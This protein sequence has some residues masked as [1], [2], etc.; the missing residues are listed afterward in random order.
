MPGGSDNKPQLT[1]HIGYKNADNWNIQAELII[2]K[3]GLPWPR[4]KCN[5]QQQQGTQGGWQQ[6]QSPPQET[7]GAR[8]AP[9]N[10]Y[11]TAAPDPLYYDQEEDEDEPD[12]ADS[13]DEDVPTDEERHAQHD[14]RAQTPNQ[15]RDSLFTPSP[16]ARERAT[17]EFRR[18]ASQPVPPQHGTAQTTAHGI[19]KFGEKD[20]AAQ[21]AL[22][23][24]IPTSMWSDFKLCRTCYD[25]VDVVQKR[26]KFKSTDAQR[27][28]KDK[29]E[30]LSL[31]AF[32]DFDAY[33]RKGTELKEEYDSH[34]K[35]M[36]LRD[37]VNHMAEGLPDDM[38]SPYLY[39]RGKY[40]NLATL[41]GIK[42][43]G[44]VYAFES[45]LR[46][47]MYTEARRRQKH[48]RRNKAKTDRPAGPPPPP[49]GQQFQRK[50]P[51]R[52]LQANAATKGREEKKN[53]NASDQKCGH[54]GKTRHTEATC[55]DLHPELRTQRQ[56]QLKANLASLQQQIAYVERYTPA[57]P[58]EQDAGEDDDN[59]SEYDNCCARLLDDARAERNSFHIVEHTHAA[60]SAINTSTGGAMEEF[61]LDSGCEFSNKPSTNGLGHLRRANGSYQGF[62][63]T[64]AAI[65]RQGD[66]LLGEGLNVAFNVV[67]KARQALLA[68]SQV[69][70]QQRLTLF[71]S[72]G[73]TV[74]KPLSPAKLQQLRELVE[75]EEEINFERK[76]G[77]YIYAQP[78][79]EEQAQG[80]EYGQDHF[81]GAARYLPHDDATADETG[82][83]EA[84]TKQ[85]KLTRAIVAI[86]TL[87][88]L[89]WLV[90]VPA[91][92][93]A[94]LSQQRVHAPEYK[95]MSVR[96]AH[97]CESH[98]CLTVHAASLRACPAT[99]SPIEE[100]KGPSKAD[101]DEDEGVQARL[102][103]DPNG[104][105]YV[106]HKVI[107]PSAERVVASPGVMRLHSQHAHAG[108]GTLQA[109]HRARTFSPPLSRELAVDLMRATHLDCEH[110]GEAKA[111]ATA[112]PKTT[113]TLTAPMQRL[114]VDGSFPT[115][116][117]STYGNTMATVAVDVYSK[118]K[119]GLY[120]KSRKQV[121]EQ[122]INLIDR[123]ERATGRKLQEL[124]LDLAPELVQGRLAEAMAKRGITIIPVPPE[125]HQH[126]G[127]AERAVGVCERGMNALMSESDAPPARWE[128]AHR[129]FI[130]VANRTL[131]ANAP[132]STTPDELFTERKRGHHHWIPFGQ[133]VSYKRTGHIGAGEYAGE[134]GIMVGYEPKGAYRI[135]R[136]SNHS[137]VTRAGPVTYYPG[138]FPWRDARVSERET[139]ARTQA[140]DTGAAQ[141]KPTA[142]ASRPRRSVLA[143]AKPA[144]FSG[145][146]YDATRKVERELGVGRP[147]FE[148]ECKHSDHKTPHNNDGADD[149]DGKDEPLAK[150][151]SSTSHKQVQHKPAKVVQPNQ[152]LTTSAPPAPSKPGQAKKQEE[153]ARRTTRSMKA[154]IGH[155]LAESA[156]QHN[157]PDPQT[158]KQALRGPEREYWLRA[159]WEEISNLRRS[160]T[161]VS[162]L[163]QDKTLEDEQ[164]RLLGCKWV[165]KK[166][167]G[168][169]GEIRYKARLVAQGFTQRE[170]VD[171]NEIFSPTVKFAT[172]RTLFAFAAHHNTTVRQL[173]VT[174]A[175]LIP[176][177]PPNERLLMR[178]PPGLKELEPDNK[179]WAWEL[180]KC[181]YGLKQSGRMWNINLHNYLI[182]LGFIRT[183]ADNCLYYK[184]GKDGVLTLLAVYV[185]DI[186][187]TGTSQEEVEATVKALRDKYEIT[188]G[189]EV[190]HVLG[191]RVRHDRARGVLELSQTA[192]IERILANSGMAQCAGMDTPMVDRL[193]KIDR[194]TN[195]HQD[196][197]TLTQGYASVLGELNYLAVATRPDIAF[198]VSQLARHLD[199]PGEK[200]YTALKRLLR[201]LQK[202]KNFCLR[203]NK[204][205][206]EM[207]LEGYADADFA[208]D[209][210]DRRSTSGYVF[211]LA[212]AAVSWKVKKQT[213]V[214]FSTCEAEVIALSYA[215][216]EALWYH[217][218][219]VELGLL[220]HDKAITIYEDNQGCICVAKDNKLSDRNKHIQ[221]VHLFCQQAVDMGKVN[222]QYIKT[223]QQV[224]D[225]NTKPLGPQALARCVRKAG[226]CNASV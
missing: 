192:Y 145:A 83:A 126:N 182:K 131:H 22:R 123:L 186:L 189:G 57:R 128:D 221:V 141:A 58:T 101:I 188:G 120:S 29:F 162:R 117:Q 66:Q 225:M 169:G 54:C 180:R 94:P 74:T 113:H 19:K 129:T 62:D 12:E 206:D 72:E 157:A 116:V 181:L 70:D 18:S 197:N 60:L 112:V 132:P 48:A 86:I 144:A 122:L 108:L 218:M 97:V 96:L 87:A 140:R 173:D 80:Q 118:K 99:A 135:V 151:T 143:T 52:D 50:A 150:P 175:Y 191:V 34:G 115:Q 8:Y 142:A 198:A 219:L 7:T 23:G 65:T 11:F 194:A 25:F 31:G 170:G 212:G 147:V 137:T 84:R 20:A 100:K 177:L 136:E 165:F 217:K 98:N 109:M 4:P 200:H 220:Q 90:C 164:D 85:G 167:I 35:S 138:K 208:G 9:R 207:A 17:P 209:K 214:A 187:L 46:G 146:E 40:T 111:T 185:D 196:V 114:S 149:D 37:F 45:E 106:T 16:R 49:R 24:T 184:R 103:R 203:Y 43:M 168:D 202:T 69:A 1:L 38:T 178:P 39:V 190:K 139:S 124:Q 95:A 176:E 159:I 127:D 119:W 166:K 21:L 224:A 68:V 6:D 226:V 27:L 163:T 82:P 160:K 42:H 56:Q 172:V 93:A 161:Y 55:W 15:S 13:D 134:F 36:K 30:D 152:P 32:R 47:V 156:I 61:A 44:D 64:R 210:E 107:K 211:T 110:C 201:Y 171:Y 92:R 88:T 223:D 153:P 199:S 174:A 76:G 154:L 125:K 179:D 216:R 183:H 213:I 195:K 215:C 155:V 77:M 73:A 59:Y 102:Q 148:E 105:V 205:G 2:K 75:Q 10:V 222:V 79:Q 204:G 133:R 71:H 130:Y 193:Y 3:Q 14:A 91:L 26:G 104:G 41:R 78:I 53:R 63:G 158:I 89:L 28:V 67:P 5:I 51:H 81:A 33:W 121:V